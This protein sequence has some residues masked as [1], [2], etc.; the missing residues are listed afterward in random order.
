MQS[1]TNTPTKST[2]SMLLW[3][4]AKA[5]FPHPLNGILTVSAPSSEPLL[6]PSWYMKSKMTMTYFKTV[7]TGMM[8]SLCCLVAEALQ[9]F[10]RRGFATP[11]SERFV[12]MLMSTY[13]RSPK[14]SSIVIQ[15]SQACPS[16]SWIL[17]LPMEANPLA[18]KNKPRTKCAL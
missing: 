5:T 13:A 8:F 1:L 4:R 12:T 16:S 10:R 7:V 6:T 11:Y 14:A 18:R 9:V 17:S 3:R 15:L 2:S